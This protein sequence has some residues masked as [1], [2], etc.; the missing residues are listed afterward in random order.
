MTQT[1]AQKIRKQE[2]TK[3]N[4]T[5]TYLK[6]KRKNQSVTLKKEESLFFILADS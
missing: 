5:K 1:N 4:S 3:E 6:K 2:T